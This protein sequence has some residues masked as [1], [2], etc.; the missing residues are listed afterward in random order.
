MLILTLTISAFKTNDENIQLLLAGD[1]SAVF[2]LLVISVFISSMASMDV[3]FYA[4]QT[5]RGD[6]VAVPEVLC[7]PGRSGAPVV[8]RYDDGG[9]VSDSESDSSTRRSR[10][11]EQMG[12]TYS[13]NN[14]MVGADENVVLF[15]RSE[16]IASSIIPTLAR[17]DTMNSGT[18]GSNRQKQTSSH[19]SGHDKLVRHETFGDLEGHRQPSLLDQARLRT[20]SSVV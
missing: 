1:Y 10:D 15:E 7:R 17:S 4:A 12:M 9:D 6:I 5:S 18:C 20:S 13:S 2:P 19:G 14:E 16:S 3:V 11:I 8:M